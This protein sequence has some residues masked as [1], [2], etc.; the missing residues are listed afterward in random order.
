M[1][2]PYKLSKVVAIA[3]GSQHALALVGSGPPVLLEQPLDRTVRP[4][5]SALFRAAAAGAWPL[6][7]QWRLNGVN[8]PRATNAWLFL[9]NV[10]AGSAGNYT[11]LVTNASGTI[12]SRVAALTLDTAS[13]VVAITSHAEL[14]VVSTNS[15]VLSGTATDAGCGDSGVGSV[16][17]K[18][19]RATNDTALG[20]GVAWW[21]RAVS[22]GGGTNTLNIV[23]TDGSGNSATNFIRIVADTSRPTVTVSNP[24]PNQRISNAVVVARG[25]ARDAAGT[26]SRVWC[27][28]NGGAWERAVGTVLWT[29]LL[30]LAPGTNTFEVCAEDAANNRSTTNLVK[31]VGAF[32]PSE[33]V[34]CVPAR[35]ER[36]PNEAASLCLVIPA[37]PVPAV[38][39][40]V[41]SD[42]RHWET[43]GVWPSA[44]GSVQVPL[45]NVLARPQGY[46]RAVPL[47]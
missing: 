23:A 7:Y 32:A 17:V 34:N 14:Q 42:L 5:G 2:V 3:A 6:R 25:S 47:Q 1:Y 22:L 46:Y 44:T 12:T 26:I 27:R 29:N 21:S 11:L 9:R 18:G 30:A 4:G 8:L 36:I 19:L 41:S 38:A 28:L 13:P 33:V 31:T 43:L 20:A 16:T 35:L 15:I 45:P 39:V 24:A 40:Q 10:Q 37:G